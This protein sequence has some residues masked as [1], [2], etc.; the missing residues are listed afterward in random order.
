VKFVRALENQC[1]FIFF[2][3]HVKVLSEEESKKTLIRL[4]MRIKIKN[5]KITIVKENR[6]LNSQWYIIDK[7]CK[8]CNCHLR[9]NIF[10]KLSCSFVKCGDY[11]K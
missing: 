7:L 3:I 9:Q 10:G 8:K 6:H 1:S 4:Q 5:G 2:G 11:E